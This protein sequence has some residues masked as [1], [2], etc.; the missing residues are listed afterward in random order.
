MIHAEYQRFLQTLNN[1]STSEGVRK[2]ANLVLAHLDEL[3]PLT[4]HQGQ[5]VKQMVALAQAK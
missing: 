2:I 4:T 3:V 1:G 5:R